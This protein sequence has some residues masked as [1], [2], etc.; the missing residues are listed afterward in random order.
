MS[1]DLP[2]LPPLAGHCNAR[3]KRRRGYCPRPGMG[4]GRCHLHGGKTPRHISKMIKH[5]SDFLPP[6]MAA[7]FE[8]LNSDMIENLGE[9]LK[10]Q[11]SMETELIERLRTGE[12]AGA[13]DELGRLAMSFMAQSSDEA[14]LAI[15]EEAFKVVQKGGTSYFAQK[16]IRGEIARTHEAQRKMTETLVKCRKE[17]QETYTE[18]EHQAFLRTVLT[19]L[20]RVATPE[21][22]MAVARDLSEQGL[23][24]L[25]PAQP[26]QK[27]AA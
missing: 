18:E 20:K 7:R 2:K 23:R 19:A 25:P 9:S 4:N 26:A 11:Q 24:V 3:M 10:I 6:E 22:L 16:E 13:W 8:V 15:A 12:S 17:V 5:R 21:V 1:R 27:E 14:K